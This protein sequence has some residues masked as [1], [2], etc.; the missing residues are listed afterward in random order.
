MSHLPK[1]GPNPIAFLGTLGA[2]TGILTFFLIDTELHR[3]AGVV[4]GLAVAAYLVKSTRI[5]FSRGVFVV[6]AFG[7]SWLAA[8]NTGFALSDTDLFDRTFGL[9]AIGAI[10]G[11]IGAGI[12]AAGCALVYQ[13]FRNLV[14][15]TRTTLIGGLAGLFLQLDTD[16]LVLLFFTGWQGLVAISL[17]LSL[18]RDG[19]KSQIRI[20]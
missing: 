12:V 15:L 6:C 10:C 11:V 17:G 3:L 20:E 5:S 8:V 13:P 19:R 18:A 9:Q 2:A 7:A 14:S 1:T 16:L 4:F